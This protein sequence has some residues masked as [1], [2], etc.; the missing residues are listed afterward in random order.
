VDKV[1]NFFPASG[2][3]PRFT[4]HGCTRFAVK[5]DFI[6]GVLLKAVAAT[7]TKDYR[8]VQ[9]QVGEVVAWR[10][11]F[12]A[13]T[14]AMARNPIPWTDGYVHPNLEYGMAYRV[15]APTAWSRVRQIILDNV[16]SGLIYIPSHALDF[17]NP[18][19]RPYLE[20]YV[21]GAGGMDAHDRVKLMK[22]LYDATISEFAGRHELYER[23]Y[24]GNHENIRLETLIVAEAVGTAERM[25]G[26]AEQCMA[27]Y[28]LEGWL[29]PDLVNNDD[30]SFVLRRFRE[31]Q[32]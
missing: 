15:L 4:F 12:W 18:A 6:A 14:D 23:N 11:L 21:R 8:G 10:N 29:T 32:G 24:A 3:I 13:I 9:A 17:Q 5:L 30:V 25:R 27:E 2:F 20:K 22:L 16:A 28:D 7:G 19:E 31:T 1:N 26:F